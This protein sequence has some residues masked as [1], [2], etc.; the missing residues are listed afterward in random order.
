MWEGRWAAFLCDLSYVFIEGASLDHLN[1][2]LEASATGG[3]GEL[4]SFL[5]I[6]NLGGS[7]LLIISISKQDLILKPSSHFLA[8]LTDLPR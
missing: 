4:V 8:L 5:S 1:E 7:A 2:N 6:I 3:G